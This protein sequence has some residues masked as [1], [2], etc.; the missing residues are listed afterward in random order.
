MAVIVNS[1][2]VNSDTWAS[3]GARTWNDARFQNTWTDM[4]QLS[5]AIEA[6]DQI[7]VAEA[8]SKH[9]T[10]NSRETLAVDE[11]EPQWDIGANP[12]EVIRV[13]E[14]L[15][16]D[17]EMPLSEIIS[18]ARSSSNEPQLLKE[19]DAFSLSDDQHKSIQPDFAEVITVLDPTAMRFTQQLSEDLGVLSLPS[20]EPG[21]EQSDGFGLQSDSWRAAKPNYLTELGLAD[22]QMAFDVYQKLAERLDMEDARAIEAWI[23]LFDSFYAASS[24]ANSVVNWLTEAFSATDGDS[25]VKVIASKSEEDF[26][27]AMSLNKDVEAEWQTIIRLAETLAKDVEQFSELSFGFAELMWRK[28]SFLRAFEEATSF[29]GSVDKKVG[30]RS[31]EV[32]KM[33]ERMIVPA[34]M[35]IADITASQMD[36]NAEYTHNDFL[37]SIDSV[38]MPGWTTWRNFMHGDYEYSKAMFRVIVESVSSDRGFIS[39]CEVAVDVPDVI[40]KGSARVSDASA[41]AGIHIEFNREYNVIPE[42]NL[43]ARGGV[44][45]NPVAAELVGSPTLIGFTAR[46]RDTITGAYVGGTFTWSSIGY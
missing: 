36:A 7:G 35:V 6:D 15:A 8:L 25:A 22:D 40:D 14:A 12:S 30:K 19:E 42:I 34:W 45:A 11:A 21:V 39:E 26:G 13:A 16:K 46:L 9:P 27:F 41:S 29:D 33:I 31:N 17:T 38:P 2:I 24:S 44:G 37:A 32:L 5:H 20:K 10:Q 3:A 28:A 1:V 4:V 23:S 18:V 43:T